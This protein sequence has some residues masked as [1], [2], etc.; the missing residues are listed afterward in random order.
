MK[1]ARVLLVALLLSPTACG[2]DLMAPAAP[3]PLTLGGEWRYRAPDLAGSVFGEPVACQYGFDMTL[4]VT[5]DAFGGTY[6][7][8]LLTCTLFGSSQLVDAG[9]GDI[10]AGSRSGASV[11]FDVDT[12]GIHNVGLLGPAGMSGSVTIE[13]IVQRDAAIDTMTVSGAW[14]A[15]R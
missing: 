3:A 8:A 6:E 15:H 4:T 10:V 12:D 11:Q 2:S 5:G 14:N 13:L 7:S 9:G 1:H